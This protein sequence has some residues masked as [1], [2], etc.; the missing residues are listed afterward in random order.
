MHLTYVPRLGAR[1]G[2]AGVI[3]VHQMCRKRSLT[4]Y[5]LSI[6]VTRS[7]RFGLGQ[8]SLSHYREE[9]E[10]SLCTCPLFGYEWSFVSVGL[11][12]RTPDLFFPFSH[13]LVCMTSPKVIY[14][15]TIWVSLWSHRLLHSHKYLILHFFSHGFNGWKEKSMLDERLQPG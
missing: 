2:N 5:S 13:G 7:R 9:S 14:W 12:I 11:F 1:C 15:L 6:H 4:Q 10:S 3:E 8:Q